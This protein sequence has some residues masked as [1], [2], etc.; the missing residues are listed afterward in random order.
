[1]CNCKSKRYFSKDHGLYWCSNCL[2]AFKPKSYTKAI[3]KVLC[4]IVIITST[5]SYI[6]AKAPN[7]VRSLIVCLPTVPKDIMLTDTSITAELIKN[8]CV[9]TNVAV[10]QSRIET[11]NYASQVCLE[12]KNL[13]GIKYHKC[14]YVSGEKNNHATFASYKD[15]IKCYCHI[16]NYYLKS[17]NGHYAEAKNYVTIIKS[18]K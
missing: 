18:F 4:A 6:E 2:I 1:M 11:G 10:T 7:A 5:F 17:I 9:L 12:N 15:C 16:Q 14:E 3:A 13:F 8:G